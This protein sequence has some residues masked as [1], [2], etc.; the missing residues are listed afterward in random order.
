MSHDKG[1]NPMR[2][3]CDRQ[4]CFNRVKRPK[5]EL[6]A[7]CLPGRIAFSDVDAVTEVCGNFLVLE[8]K[9]HQ[10]LG[11]GQRVLFERLTRLCPVTVLL[12]EADVATMTVHS[13][14]V[15]A[16]G[17]ISPWQPADLDDLRARIQAWSDMAVAH[18]PL[19]T[20][21]AACG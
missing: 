13:I 12:V 9:D 17:V 20:E 21:P 18:F 1:F 5:I 7:D 16:E 11:T 6:F 2:W 10:E 14:A 15:V 3:E 4:G 8:F 19:R